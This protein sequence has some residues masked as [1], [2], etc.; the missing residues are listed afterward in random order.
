MAE[1]DLDITKEKA[2]SYRIS[3]AVIKRLPRYFRYLRELM[4]QGRTRISS[5]ELSKLMNLTASQIRQDLNCFGGFG[6]QGYGYNVEFLYG[7]ISEILGV[8]ENYRAIIIGAG[9]LGRALVGSPMFEKR[10]IT[11][12]ALFDNSPMLVGTEHGTLHIY[13]VSE[14]ERYIKENAIDMAVLTLPRNHAKETAELLA[15]CGIK[16]IWNFTNVELDIDDVGTV[17]QNVHIGDSLMQLTYRM[18]RE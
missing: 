7:K 1:K 8:K 13:D 15:S 10:G 2:T 17:V 9:H 3:S 18:S 4:A 12:S 11:I 14:L 16:G 5:A 6:Q